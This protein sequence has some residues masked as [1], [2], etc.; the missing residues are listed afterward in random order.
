[1]S[2]N[3]EVF[4]TEIGLQR[5]KGIGVGLHVRLTGMHVYIRCTSSGS[6]LDEAANE[7]SARVKNENTF[8]CRLWSNYNAVSTTSQG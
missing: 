8:R 6:Q 5:E 3:S 4:A 1:M 2:N 7:N